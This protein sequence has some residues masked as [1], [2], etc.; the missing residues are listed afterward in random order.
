MRV[1]DICTRQADRSQQ[2]PARWRVLLGGLGLACAAPC[3]EG[4]GADEQVV[5]EVP[6]PSAMR[7]QRQLRSLGIEASAQG[8]PGDERR[9][10]TVGTKQAPYA[11][12]LVDALFAENDLQRSL[13]AGS[14]LLAAFGGGSR[15]TECS[16][17]QRRAEIEAALER[18]ASVV[19]ARLEVA[20]STGLDDRVSSAALLLQT[21]PDGAA[22][23]LEARARVYVAASL[24]GL[25][26]SDVVVEVEPLPQ[27]EGTGTFIE[28]VGPF[29]VAERSAGLLRT[30]LIVSQILHITAVAA[31]LIMV[32]RRRRRREGSAPDAS[33]G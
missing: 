30:T 15:T 8:A 11:A 16:R 18:F 13:C 2:G 14:S 7:L 1:A 22:E 26:A 5:A 23:H 17:I 29:A 4:C 21:T 33:A 25:D 9:A 32:F 31:L 27:G 24:A 10:L 6:E 20:T 19:S 28:K 3:L 12:R